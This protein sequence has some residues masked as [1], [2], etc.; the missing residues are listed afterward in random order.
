MALSR[1]RSSGPGRVVSL[2]SGAH[3]VKVAVDGMVGE[4]QALSELAGVPLL[5]VN[6]GQHPQQALGR[7]QTGRQTRVGEVPLGPGD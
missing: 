5:A 4:P 2:I 7:L 3:I 6:G 1:S